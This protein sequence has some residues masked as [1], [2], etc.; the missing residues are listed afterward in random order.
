M[1]TN[2][3]M[4]DPDGFS[5]VELLVT[6]AIL[7]TFVAAIAPLMEGGHRSF[8]TERAI[9]DALDDA[10]FAMGRIAEL[11]RGAGSNPR[12]VRP[13]VPVTID[14]G[15]TTVRLLSDFN[16]DGDLLDSPFGTDGIASLPAPE[17]VTLSLVGTTVM[18]QD[19]T[20]AAG[21]LV[22]VAEDVV[23]LAFVALPGRIT[24]VTVGVRSVQN[25][26][27]PLT[28]VVTLVQQVARRN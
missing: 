1:P 20:P 19:N 24:T 13:L 16:G 22:P 18:M 5:M 27:A 7:T 3:R 17:D 12:R 26:G 11:V 25:P 2:A 10:R 8:S 23:S 28:R 15:G 21:G 4:R 14:P 6:I 9:A